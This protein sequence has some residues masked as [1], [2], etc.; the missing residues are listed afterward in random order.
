MTTPFLHKSLLFAGLAC[1]VLAWPFS[2]Y[3]P[4]RISW[5]NGILENTQV[6]VLL[7]TGVAACL[8]Y[9]RDRSGHG[10]IWIAG[11]ILWFL[12]AA[13]EL[14]W[15]AVFMTPVDMTPHGPTFSSALLWYRPAV[16][17]AIAA[18]LAVVVVYLCLSR[19]VGLVRKM[20][21]QKSVPIVEFAGFT[22]AMLIST[23]AE[24]HMGMNLD[25]WTGDLQVLEET[26]ETAAYLFLAAGQIKVLLGLGLRD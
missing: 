20:A 8:A 22:V 4:I 11:A 15:G 5:E 14:S 2:L 23:A 3:L 13:R 17:P 1:L 16:T 6:F 21:A 18:L 7:A 24:G 25:A 19:P 12:L 26:V 9:R 10:N